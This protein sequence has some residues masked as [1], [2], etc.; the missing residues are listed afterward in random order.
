MHPIGLY[1]KIQNI[2]INLELANK[3]NC[4]EGID[5]D[6]E[7]AMMSRL[8][9][10]S[11][12]KAKEPK[13]EQ[14]HHAAKDNKLTEPPASTGKKR[15]YSQLSSSSSEDEDHS[16]YDDNSSYAS[17]LDHPYVDSRQASCE[18]ESNAE[19]DDSDDNSIAFTPGTQ[20]VIPVTKIIDLE[21]PVEVQG[22]DQ[23]AEEYAFMDNAAFQVC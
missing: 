6:V 1:E 5:S 17:A 23:D 12:S 20:D 19:S 15:S 18:D 7:D 9:Y 22:N 13:K 4:S 21:K 16:G 10:T 3:L 14:E 11:N 2:D 8:Y